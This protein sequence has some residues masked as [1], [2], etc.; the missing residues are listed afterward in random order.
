MTEKEMMSVLENG[1]IDQCTPEQRQQ[2]FAFAF[3][4]EYMSSEDKGQIK[5]YSC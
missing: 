5:E 3:G 4:E 2:V 1:T